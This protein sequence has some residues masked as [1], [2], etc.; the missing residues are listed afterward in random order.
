ML[1]I[2]AV[3]TL[4]TFSIVNY[5]KETGS[6]IS[7]TSECGTNG[8]GTAGTKGLSISFPPAQYDLQISY[9]LE[10]NYTQLE[11]NVTATEQSDSF[12]YGPIYLVNGLSDNGYWFQLGLAWNSVNSNLT[13]FSSGFFFVYELSTPNGKSVVP[14]ETGSVYSAFSRSVN[15]DDTVLL[16]LDIKGGNISMSAYDW[17]TTAFAGATFRSYGATSFIGTSNISTRFTG[18]MLEWYHACSKVLSPNYTKYSDLLDEVDAAHICIDQ[19]SVSNSATNVLHTSNLDNLMF[20]RCNSIQII[21]DKSNALE[22]ISINGLDFY[23]NSHTFI[24]D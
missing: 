4:A 1:T 13:G 18:L 9:Q 15:N 20:S 16:A 3:T 7:S 6:S 11:Y 2:L 5:E 8:V 23:A 12:G 21:N 22:K 24:I 10:N 17:N 19:W 14:N